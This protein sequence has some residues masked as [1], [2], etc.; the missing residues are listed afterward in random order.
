MN[1]FR[2]Y[3]LLAGA[4]AVHAPAVAQDPNVPPP[5]ASQGTASGTADTVH[6]VQEMPAFPRG[7]KAYAR[8]IKRNVRYPKE[9][10]KKDLQGKV[11]V[12]FTI[13]TTGQV[14]D[15][16]V[17]RGVPGAPMLDEEAVRVIKSMPRWTPGRS[18]GK[19]VKVRF[20]QKISFTLDKGGK[21]KKEK[22]GK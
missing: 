7:E 20:V 17:R 16:E 11:Y 19:P 21:G 22:G 12:E 1:S 2:L 9:A 14:T 6:H 3:L 18:D 13:D 4:I 15:V 5:P 10:Y 8:F